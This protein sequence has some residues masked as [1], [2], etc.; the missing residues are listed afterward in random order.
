MPISARQEGMEPA[1]EASLGEELVE[2]EFRSQAL[3]NAGIGIWQLSP[4]TDDLRC[5]DTSARLLGYS[6]ASR[7]HSAADLLECV[8]LADRQDVSLR[9]ELCVLLGTPVSLSFQSAHA[10]D[11]PHLLEL[12]ASRTLSEDGKPVV[13]GTLRGITAK[14]FTPDILRDSESRLATV[15]SQTMVGIL[16]RDGDRNVL[17]VNDRYLELV[18]R[19]AEELSG[20]PFEEITHPDDREWTATLLRQK[21]AEGE[22][23]TV[24]MRYV[25]PDGSTI[26]CEVNVSFV[27]NP[28][29]TWN[30]HLIFAHDISDR[31]SAEAER[32][33]AQD[34]L[35]LA[36]DGAGAGTWEVDFTE[37]GLL[38]LSPN[39][40]R[41]YGLPQD[42]A[43]LLTHE[44]WSALLDSTSL[45][46]MNEEF[47]AFIGS[48]APHAAEFKVRRADGEERWLRIHGRAILDEAGNPLKIVGLIYDD[49][50]RKRADEELRH[51]ELRVRW[52]AEHDTLTE[53]PNRNYFD[54]Q[55]AEVLTAAQSSG[56]K[57]GL[58]VLDVDNFKQVN[59]AFGHDAG[60]ILLKTLSQRLEQFL[61]DGDFAA[62][63]GGD[64]FALVVRHLETGRGFLAIGKAINE[65]M[66]EP[67]AHQGY[68]LDCGVSI[69]A[70]TFP[71]HGTVRDE[72]LKSADIALYAAKKHGRNNILL[73]ESSLRSELNRRTAMIGLAR[74]ALERNYIAPYYQPKVCLR[75][76][77][78]KGFEA[79]L[80]WRDLSGTVHYPAEM[81]AAFED[82]ELAH[83]ISERIQDCV[84]DDI[85]AWLDAGLEFEQV[86]INAAAAEFSRND[87]AS[88][89]LGKLDAAGVP[90]RHLQVEVTETVFLGRGAD[91]VGFA[92]DALK[93]R[94]VEIA[95]DDFGTGYASLSHLKNFPVDVIK[96]DRSFITDLGKNTGDTAIVCALL[97]LAT[98]LGLTTV[99]EGIETEAQAAFLERK[100]CDFGQGYFFGKAV[101]A[102]QVPALLAVPNLRL[103]HRSR[104][105]KTAA[106]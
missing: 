80:R 32:K 5:D 105:R 20:L 22:P 43:G 6:D 106:R 81:E 25:R 45:A 69:G 100:G 90:A 88:R 101:S 73:F 47:G 55:L 67:I 104:P 53:L 34:M 48:E 35:T 30:S 13:I 91:H 8:A 103:A 27:L 42:H 14:N 50:A 39:A 63:I 15:F 59:D 96:I 60:D 11:G 7:P 75:S 9:L 57:I 21:V 17:M 64:E 29:G 61:E 98:D 2:G 24:E 72:L 97:G 85:R 102:G 84:I 36:L 79:L 4:S 94:G 10:G 77:K 68:I 19:T 37:N 66:K 87:F 46:K 23:F 51:S 70:A 71:E 62:R 86:A 26:W 82:Y 44:E 38:R 41:I 1:S 18:G 40:L 89:L 92:L 12:T 33:R 76:G 99:A 54:D 52:I 58:L 3:A 78:T 31:K 74:S 83:E 95:L 93:A 56:E 49:S 28:D 16:H 65:R